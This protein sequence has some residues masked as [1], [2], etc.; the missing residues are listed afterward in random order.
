MPGWLRCARRRRHIVHAA[1]KLLRSIYK[2]G[3]AYQKTGVLLS[4]LTPADKRQVG[5][6]D[7]TAALQKSK[8]LMEALDR[9]NRAYG[10]GT[11][12]LL[13][14]GCEAEWAM[15]AEKRSPRYTTRLEEIPNC[16]TALKSPP[17][18]LRS[19]KG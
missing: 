4:E 15:K 9:V 6:F 18:K 14:E 1:T 12:K 17:V 5:L 13:A 7:D 8:G 3:F 10:R 19:T 11:V 2:E 16:V